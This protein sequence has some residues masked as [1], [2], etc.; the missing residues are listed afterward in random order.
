MTNINLNT[1]PATAAPIFPSTFMGCINDCKSAV[2]KTN[3][4]LKTK[5][6]VDDCGELVYGRSPDGDDFRHHSFERRG[7]R[8]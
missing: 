5:T 4:S 3:N 6:K 8:H 2:Y 1:M 7:N